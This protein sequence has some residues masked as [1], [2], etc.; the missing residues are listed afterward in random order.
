M[1]SIFPRRLA[2]ILFAGLSLPLAA[3]P[4]APGS[5]QQSADLGGTP[6]EIYTYRPP[7][8]EP[9]AW[10]LVFH[11][12]GRNAADYRD[13]ARPLADA[14]CAVVVAPLF[15][16]RRF[17]EAAYQRGGLGPA[18]PGPGTGA[19]VERLVDW[20]RAGEPG[21]WPYAVIGHSAGAQFLGRYAAATPNQAVAIVLANPGSYL[22]PTLQTPLPD[23][24]GGMPDAEQALRHYLA[25]PIV[26]LLGDDD[27]K[28]GKNLPRGYDDEGAN[29]HERG[30]NFFHA[31]ER[32]AAERHWD[33]HWRLLEVPGV[34]HNAGGMFASPQA[35]QAL[36]PLR[37]R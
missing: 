16:K 28:R 29:R 33:F 32:V 23:G 4:I 6:I 14:L 35:L 7:Q 34:A 25:E 9:H 13:D 27:V 30:L 12:M 36:E 3:A 17:P 24:F 20:L 18:D 2:A 26:V 37:G 19:E 5:S 31:G 21:N 1:K 8:C 22:F 11:G 10:L 15:D